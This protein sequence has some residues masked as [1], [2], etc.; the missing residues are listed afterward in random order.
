MPD[1]WLIFENNLCQNFAKL[2]YSITLPVEGVMVLNNILVNITSI[3]AELSKLT[4]SNNSSVGGNLLIGSDEITAPYRASNAVF[5]PLDAGTIIQ[6]KMVARNAA[7]AGFN[8][9][10]LTDNVAAIEGVSAN[11]A[12]VTSEAGAGGFQWF[13]SSGT[14][15]GSFF[16]QWIPSTKRLKFL[17]NIAGGA[18]EFATPL[19]APQLSVC[20][21]NASAVAAGLAIGT[22]YKTATGEVRVV[23]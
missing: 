17:N 20:A 12:F 10:R 1:K 15:A 14:N 11:I 13:S 21:D 6:L 18:V 5:G 23:V 19:I 8:Y 4:G 2:F 22:L 16:Q 9:S 7:I 3:N